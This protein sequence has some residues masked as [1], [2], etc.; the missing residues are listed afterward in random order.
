MMPLANQEGANSLSRTLMLQKACKTKVEAS[1]ATAK[2]LPGL[3][4]LKSD[5]CPFMKQPQWL[6]GCCAIDIGHVL[7]R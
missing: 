1:T 7:E 3:K 4:L 6:A 2:Y 5:L